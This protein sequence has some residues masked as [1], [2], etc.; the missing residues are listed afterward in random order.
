MTVAAT[1]DELAAGLAREPVVPA[2]PKPATEVLP[3]WRTILQLRRNALTT[4]GEPAY[5]HDIFSRPFMGRTSFLVSHPD[6]IRRVLVDNHAN[7]GRTPATIRI[8]RPILGDGLFLAEGAPGSTSGAPWP[9]PS[10][11]AAWT[12]PRGHIAQVAEETMAELTAR[13][14]GG[15]RPAAGRAAPGPGDRRP[16]V[17]LAGHA[18]ARRR[19]ARR[20]RA[21]RQPARAAVLPR[22]P[23]AGR[24]RRARSTPPAGGSRATSSACSTG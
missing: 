18:R 10:P 22:L 19:P 14:T 15:G 12:S 11:R 17:L 16:L 6:G 1:W 7:Y 4:W 8:L 13:G 24:E 9:P 21:L 3:L 5:E 23:A 2:A 20:L